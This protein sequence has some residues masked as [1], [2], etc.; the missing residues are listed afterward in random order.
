MSRLSFC[1]TK[2]WSPTRLTVKFLSQ[3]QGS[4]RYLGGRHSFFSVY[5]ASRP[6]FVSSRTFTTQSF[7]VPNG[8]SNKIRRM[9]DTTDQ[10]YSTFQEVKDAVAKFSIKPPEAVRG[11]TTLDRS[12]FN[13]NLPLLALAVDSKKC[14]DFLSKLGICLLNFPRMRNVVK[15]TTL[16]DE[17]KRLVLLSPIFTK[18]DL[19]QLPE[20]ARKFCQEQGVEVVHYN[21]VLEYDYW[22][23]EQVLCAVLPADIK[24][25]TT[26][27][28]AVGHIA[29]MNLRDCHLP[30][31][32]LIGQVVLDKNPKLKTV[33]NKMDSIDTTFRFFKMEVLAGEDNFQT[34]VRENNCVFRFDYSNVYWNS[35]LGTE[36]SR[37]LSLFNKSDVVCDMFAGVGP[38]VIPACKRGC[39]VY[40]NDLNPASYQ[41]MVDNAKANKLPAA[42]YKLYNLDAREFVRKVTEDVRQGKDGCPAYHQVVMNL[43]A[44]A[45][46]FLDAFVGL[47]ADFPAGI[48]MPR[49]HCYCFSKD[50]NPQQDA[51]NRVQAVLGTSLPS[52]YF[53]VFD[54]RDVAPQ[55]LMMCVSFDLPEE[56]A[57]RKQGQPKDIEPQATKRE[58]EDEESGPDA[59]KQKL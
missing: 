7:I 15:E 31:K 13:T 34:E 58:G 12:L 32:N 29:H 41:A 22:N 55:K 50:E 45:I 3:V 42:K 19:S 43:P 23:A 52:E 44:D 9:S 8:L 17:L 18:D 16:V 57:R 38:F 2:L 10:V 49:I 37:L 33:V 6:L 46:E 51:I 26:A 36:H 5:D 39:F 27:F 54:V 47:Y 14:S 53:K 4:N 28:E 48:K 1:L 25:V 40:G 24:E 20:D 56:A 21:Q 11:L 35:R 59:K 30:Y